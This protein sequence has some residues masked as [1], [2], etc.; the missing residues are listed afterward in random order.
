MAKKL[1]HKDPN[2]KDLINIV[3][4]EMGINP[5]LVEKDYW[6]MHVLY[7]L[8]AQKFEFELK[9]GTSLSKGYKIIHRFSE[10]IDLKI[11]PPDGMNVMTGKNHVKGAQI[12][13][14][15]DFFDW[16]A[17]EIKI[18]G[19]KASREYTFDD[20]KLRNAGI[21][22]SFKSVTEPISGIKPVVLLETGFD[23]TTPNKPITISSWAYDK[24]SNVSPNEYIDN[25][26]VDVKCYIP[27]FTF[28]EKLQAIATKFRKYKES[29]KLEKNFMRHYYDVY[30]L[31]DMPEIKNFLGTE[32]YIKR[33]LER[34]PKLDE[35]EKLKSNPAFQITDKKDFDLLSANY[36]A[37][38]NLYYQGQPQWELILKRIKQFSSSF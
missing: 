37:T 13:T 9:G 14:R 6:I 23:D 16:I 32:A 19:V 31:L 11:I 2:F 36:K 1:L 18:D 29:G 3:A 22:L 26:A 10:D 27:E 28:V 4:S 8:Q 20:E 33:K 35:P 38:E 12:K 21:N 24:A 5:Y 25:R 15:S 30:C 34:F 17:K 7:G